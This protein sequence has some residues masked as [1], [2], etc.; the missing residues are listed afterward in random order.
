MNSH[1]NNL[2]ATAN[3]Y[4]TRDT[5][6]RRQLLDLCTDMFTVLER[7]AADWDSESLSS[8]RMATIRVQYMT[9][10]NFGRKP[11]L[12]L[13]ERMHK[14]V[15]NLLA[16]I[17]GIGDVPQVDLTV[18]QV[19]A[20][21]PSSIAGEYVCIELKVYPLR[22]AVRM[23]V[24]AQKHNI[25]ISSSSSSSNNSASSD[26]WNSGDDWGDG[27]GCPTRDSGTD[28]ADEDHCGDDDSY[29]SDGRSVSSA[30]CG[31]GDYHND[32]A[33]DG[34]D[35]YEQSDDCELEDSDAYAASD[36][37]G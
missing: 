26:E 12:K 2:D 1:T 31:S 11:L 35:C 32:S 34:D 22:I 13:C 21:I 17:T 7:N 24:V 8:R 5:L 36:S 27:D 29:N 4:N 28:S 10:N 25:S 3:Q 19:D 15:E 6:S 20:T 37:S 9:M 18:P 33:D 30:E 14:L 16:P 23:L